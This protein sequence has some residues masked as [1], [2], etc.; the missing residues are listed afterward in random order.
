MNIAGQMQSAGYNAGMGFYYGLSST[1]GSIYSLANR[2]ANTVAS[3]IRR[4]LNTHSPSRVMMDIGKNTGLG[5]VLGM[6]SMIGKA[7]RTA[8][9][10]ADTAIF[11][12]GGLSGSLSNSLKIDADTSSQPI[13]LTLSLG[14]RLYRAFV[15]DI[16]AAQN[17]ELELVE[18]Y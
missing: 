16:T 18:V 13:D 11:D 3:T 2:I 10:L 8:D 12:A 7:Q 6:D 1:A 5:F 4:A 9:N 15:A 14:G 17:A